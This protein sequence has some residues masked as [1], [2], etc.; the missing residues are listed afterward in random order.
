MT[1]HTTSPFNNRDYRLLFAAQV[2]SLVGTG[3]TT[4]A[5]ALLVLDL[6]GSRAGEVL[7]IALALK[8]V[9]YVF[10]APIM[11]A[12]SA[13]IPRR[14]WLIGMDL[15]RAAMVLC[16]PFVSEIWQIYL[17][18]VA[19]NLCAAS[20]TPVFQATVPSVLRDEEQYRKA[21][22]Y[23]QIAY[24][25]EQLLSPTLA[26]LLLT[27]MSYH[28]L[29]D[30]NALTFGV[31]ALLIGLTVVPAVATTQSA[32]LLPVRIFGNV[33]S[34][35]IAYIKT[36]R[37]R[38][39]WAIYFAVA[40][41]SAMII[42]NTVIYVMDFLGL[43]ESQLA[44]TLA[45]AGLGSITGAFLTPYILR[46]LPH[47]R[48][49]TSGC[50]LLSLCL[51][52]G[53]SL[54]GWQMLIPLWFLMGLGLGLVQTPVGSLVRMSCHDRDSAQLFAANFS[55]SHAC[56]F[57]GYLLAGFLA[58]YTSWPITFLTLGL[59]ASVATLTG[60]YL[61]PDPDLLEIEHAHEGIEHRNTHLHDELH[62]P[63]TTADETHKHEAVTHRH[64]YVIDE[65][66]STWV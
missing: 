52:G 32:G 16:M 48:I 46:H 28:L 2:T 63:V 38:A 11:S 47:S 33:F 44:I 49:M 17:L 62:A 30:L 66:H 6:S 21:L 37:L 26:A 61:F 31:S 10:A 18:V 58:T 41:A 55:L 7:G 42:V 40:V 29:F 43:T 4:I 57:F 39:T 51:L 65:H 23:A 59:L 53:A 24:S 54:P 64:H 60:W 20:F 36:P 35:V 15:A 1:E 22:S 8:M 56:W 3:V 5:L 12:L 25:L 45:A 50:L 19:I 9:V 27:M 14:P 13:R 34:G